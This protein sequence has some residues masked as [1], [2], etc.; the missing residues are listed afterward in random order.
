MIA[1]RHTTLSRTPLDEWPA[2]QHTTLTTDRHPSPSGIQTH[3]PS[4]QVAADPRLRPR[5]WDRYLFYYRL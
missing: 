3:N 4:K 5:N 1:F 2:R